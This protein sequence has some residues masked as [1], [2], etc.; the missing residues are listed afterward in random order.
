[1]ATKTKVKS[2]SKGSEDPAAD[3]AAER[4]E[5][6]NKVRSLRE[7]GTKWEEIATTLGMSTG[8]AM[9][10]YMEATTRPKDRIKGKTDEELGAAIVE[11]RDEQLLSWGQI[12]ARS[13]LPETRCRK[14]YEEAT[15]KST[16]GNRIGKGGRYPD[17]TVPPTRAGEAKERAVKKAAAKKAA[18]K[19]TAAKKSPAK[20]SPAKKASGGSAKAKLAAMSDEALIEH[21]VG[22]TL[23]YKH[24]GSQ[25]KAKVEDVLDLTGEGEAREITIEKDDGNQAIVS[26]SSIISVR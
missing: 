9:L 20:K 18:A 1:M 12:S 22:K 21:I 10:L 24:S 4:E 8:K 19:K 15:G 26:L 23:S 11:A 16:R 2:K 5:L 6:R 3:R 17:G 25:F 7:D 14:L 13:G